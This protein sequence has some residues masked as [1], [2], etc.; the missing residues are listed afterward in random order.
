LHPRFPSKTTI[1]WTVTALRFSDEGLETPSCRNCRTPLNVHQPD[2][3]RP[4]HLLGTCPHCGAWY[5]IELGK[6]KTEAFMFDL[7]N[8]TLVHALKA[9][10]PSATKS[11]RKRPPKRTAGNT[12]DF[13]RWTTLS[14]GLL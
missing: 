7:P 13:S 12:I 2:E 5:L 6:E 4:E 3:D 1:T 8:V 11:P 9:S 10:E 14:P